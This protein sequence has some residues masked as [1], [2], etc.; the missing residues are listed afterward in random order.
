MT[1]AS[2]VALGTHCEYCANRIFLEDKL[3]HSNEC[4]KERFKHRMKTWDLLKS[5][6]ILLPSPT[7]TDSHPSAASAKC[8]FT[9]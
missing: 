1:L 2:N 7:E 8:S 6:G 9:Y 5:V 4:L 3:C